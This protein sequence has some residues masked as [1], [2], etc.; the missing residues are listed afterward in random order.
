MQDLGERG[1]PLRLVAQES[2][3][4]HELQVICSVM[5][6]KTFWSQAKLHA[7]GKLE[8]DANCKLLQIWRTPVPVEIRESRSLDRPHLALFKTHATL[9]VFSGHG[10]RFPLPDARLCEETPRHFH[11]LTTWRETHIPDDPRCSQMLPDDPR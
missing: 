7:F 3:L 1:S 11:Q 10:Q 4:L 6:R 2:Q 9:T 5:V 8:H